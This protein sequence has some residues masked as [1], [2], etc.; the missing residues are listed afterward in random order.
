MKL[1]INPILKYLRILKYTKDY[2]SKGFDVDKNKPL[3]VIFFP[4]ENWPVFV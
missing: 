2:I 1:L 3:K 4:S